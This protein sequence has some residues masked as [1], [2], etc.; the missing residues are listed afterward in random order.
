MYGEV[1]I[2]SNVKIIDDALRALI[3][4]K[5]VLFPWTFPVFPSPSPESTDT[6]VFFA[7][8]QKLC[9]GAEDG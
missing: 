9:W 8:S 6:R 2:Y 5:N 7:G 1:Q 3:L 4:S